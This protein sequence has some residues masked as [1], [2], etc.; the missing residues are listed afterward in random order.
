MNIQEK[1]GYNKNTIQDTSMLKP[2]FQ[3]INTDKEPKHV[4]WHIP[5]DG[6]IENNIKE[7]GEKSKGY[8]IM[9]I[10]E[11]RDISKKYNWLMYTGIFLGPLAALLSGIG[12]IINPSDAPVEFP[13]AAACAGFM[14]GIVVAI[15]KFGKFEERSS[16][17]KLAASK[18]TSLES[19][20]RRQLILCRT[21]RIN[22]GQYL[23][24][25]GNSFDELFLASPL[26]ARNIYEKYVE[27]AHKNG[28]SVPDEYEITINIDEKYQV[29]KFKELKDDTVIDINVSPKNNKEKMDFQYKQSFKGNTEIKRTKTLSHFPELNKFSDGRMG[30]EMERMLGLK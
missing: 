15:T 16:H 26:V 9:H 14:S 28:I 27:L 22:A 11:A 2:K 18:Y 6:K 29:Q 30:Y 23:E 19:N 10:Q 1:Q 17:H 8:K 21:D 4:S 24:W 25:I 7:I 3:S 20:V 5:W 13:I 12:A